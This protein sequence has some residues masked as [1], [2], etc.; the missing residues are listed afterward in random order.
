M[1]AIQTR[2]Q[3]AEWLLFAA[4]FLIEFTL[5]SGLFIVGPLTTEIQNSIALSDPQVG[6]LTSVPTLMMGLT[7]ILGGRLADGWGAER[8]IA[9]GMTLVGVGGAMRGFTTSAGMLILWSVL[10]G[11]GIGIIFSSIPSIARQ[12]FPH[13]LGLFNAMAAFALTIGVILA[14]VTSTSVL[15][16]LLGGWQG[17]LIFWGVAA[18]VAMGIW[19]VVATPWAFGPAAPEQGAPTDAAWN[20]LKIPAVWFVAVLFAGQGLVYFLLA[21]W[22]PTLYEE[23]GFSAG[24]GTLRV[25]LL[26]LGC[27]I[28]NFL[29]PWLSSKMNSRRAPMV[30]STLLVTVSLVGYLLAA[31]SPGIDLILPIVAGM[32]VS[33]IFVMVMIRIAE[34][35]P[36]GQTGEAAALVISVGYVL[37]SLGPWVAGMIRQSTGSLQQALVFL[38]V[39]SVVL[40]PFALA[41]PRRIPSTDEPAMASE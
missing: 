29:M 39:V 24:A 38:L 8:T 23:A 34:V 31:T 12:W 21:A 4:V 32:G 7:A 27:L 15:S 36:R 41:M 1:L 17:A 26:G 9:L 33:G 28:A 35:A 16:P 10:L 40:I 30:L 2:P 22:V 20:P 18:L 11:A 5:E 6:L 25:S 3:R 19:L 37:T 14:Q 13:Q